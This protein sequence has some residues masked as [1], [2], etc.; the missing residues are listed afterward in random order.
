MAV[1]DHGVFLGVIAQWAD[2]TSRTGQLPGAAPFHNVNQREF[3]R[4]W[5]SQ[6]RTVLFR[7]NMGR[8]RREPA[9]AL[10]RFEAWRTN[11]PAVASRSFDYDA[12]LDA[13]RDTIL[14]AERH[15]DPGNFTTFIAYEWTA[16]TA[17][18]SPP[19]IT[20]T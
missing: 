7:E 12:H 15:N 5:A 9:D 6:E 1:T 18:R 13:W 14:A 20:A 11:N 16:S 8:F 19:R 17:R 4:H 2:P 10:T 3:N